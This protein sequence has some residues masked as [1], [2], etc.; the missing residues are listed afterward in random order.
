M[1][2]FIQ[3]T[4]WPLG[5]YII[6]CMNGVNCYNE[7][8]SQ[9][10]FLFWLA[11]ETILGGICAGEQSIWRARDR[12]WRSSF[13]LPDCAIAAG[14]ARHCRHRHHSVALPLPQTLTAQPQPGTLSSR[15]RPVSGLYGPL[16]KGLP[17]RWPIRTKCPQ[18]PCLSRF[19]ANIRERRCRWSSTILW[20]G[21]GTCG[22]P[23]RDG[24]TS[25]IWGYSHHQQYQWQRW[26]WE[27]N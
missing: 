9:N 5:V 24:A 20:R 22:R 27:V 2:R 12:G 21:R 17:P 6:V 25:T 26:S 7:Y 19:R 1:K 14:C 18:Q 15:P 16:G 4:L 10:T 23:Y 11:A 3:W 8:I 13:S